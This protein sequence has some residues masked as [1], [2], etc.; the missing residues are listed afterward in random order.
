MEEMA[1]WDMIFNKTNYGK[2]RFDGY[3]VIGYKS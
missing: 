2:S 1:T 3:N